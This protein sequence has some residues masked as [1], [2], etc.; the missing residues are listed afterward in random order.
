MKMYIPKKN[1]GEVFFMAVFL[2]TSLLIRNAISQELYPN[3]PV[4]LVVPWGRG[5]TSDTVTRVF[6]KVAEKELGQPIIVENK[7]GAGGSIGVNYVLKS[8]PDG[9]TLGVPQTSSYIIH[10]HIKKVPFD[11]L[12]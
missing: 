11:P 4:T 10:L 2:V 5:G 1:V 8:K 9:Y 3:R 6:A 12:T 7:P